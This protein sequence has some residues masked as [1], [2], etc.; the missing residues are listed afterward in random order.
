MSSAT[1]AASGSSG[2]LGDDARRER[3][4]HAPPAQLLEVEVLLPEGLAARPQ[5]ERLVHRLEAQ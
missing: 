5:P 1:V 2:A 4:E 3:H